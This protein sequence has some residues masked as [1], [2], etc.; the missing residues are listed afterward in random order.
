MIAGLT[1]DQ[2]IK[3][4]HDWRGCSEPC[5]SVRASYDFLTHLGCEVVAP[6]FP[7][8]YYGQVYMLDAPSLNV[9][10][11]NHV[12]V[13]DTR[14]NAI[15][16]FKVYDPNVGN[17]GKKVYGP[18][19]NLEGFSSLIRLVRRSKEC[20]ALGIGGPQTKEVNQ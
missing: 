6:R 17:E 16:D 12:L 20:E 5:L 3:E 18:N 19:W 9:E 7:E 10:K 15:D 2:A 8:I 4:L 1:W 13:L 14:C 11:V